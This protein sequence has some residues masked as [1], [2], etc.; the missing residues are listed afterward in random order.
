MKVTHV[1]TFKTSGKSVVSG[2]RHFITGARHRHVKA[3]VIGSRRVG[4]HVWNCW[5][6]VRHAGTHRT[7][8]NMAQGHLAVIVD[9]RIGT[10]CR[11]ALPGRWTPG[12]RGAFNDHYHASLTG[13]T[14]L[15]LQRGDQSNGHRRNEREERVIGAETFV[16]IMALTSGGVGLIQ[17]TLMV[18]DEGLPST[19]TGWALTGAYGAAATVGAYLL[20][21]SDRREKRIADEFQAR[22]DAIEKAHRETL[23][24]RDEEHHRLQARYERLLRQQY[25]GGMAHPDPEE[26]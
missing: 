1:Q 6:M 10:A 14:N 5:P 11:F 20:T 7:P 24:E 9:L 8:A 4:S 22:L 12:P 25:R 15:V 2:D 16:G 13:A 18:A 3:S 26:D 19:P 17:T 23:K 21:R